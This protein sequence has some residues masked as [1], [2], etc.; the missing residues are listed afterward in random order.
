[1]SGQEISF[2]EIFNNSAFRMHTKFQLKMII[3][4]TFFVLIE[5]KEESCLKLKGTPEKEKIAWGWGWSLR[6]RLTY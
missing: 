6:R 5:V 4:A 3:E 1:M 2:T